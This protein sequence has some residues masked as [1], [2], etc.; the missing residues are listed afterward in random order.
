MSVSVIGPCLTSTNYYKLKSQS[1]LKAPRPGSAVAKIKKNLFGAVDR[2]ANRKFVREELARQAKQASEKWK[3]DFLAGLPMENQNEFEWTC[4]VA[5]PTVYTLTHAAHVIESSSESEDLLDERADKAN[6]FFIH[7]DI[8][9][10]PASETTSPTAPADELP[11][12]GHR[13]SYHLRK[14]SANSKAENKRQPKITDFL[15]EKKKSIVSPLAKKNSSPV[16]L[17]KS[18]TLPSSPLRLTLTQ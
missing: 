4:T 14:L 13:S 15:K 9:S 6:N 2:E 16:A 3:F 10:C 12:R 7:C 5:S 18:R 17:S 8:P 1:Q 11:V